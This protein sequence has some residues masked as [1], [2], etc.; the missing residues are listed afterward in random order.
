MGDVCD[1]TQL[2]GTGQSC[3]LHSL[4]LI[5]TLN[6][7]LSGLFHKPLLHNNNLVVLALHVH[8]SLPPLDLQHCNCRLP[9]NTSLFLYPSLSQRRTLPPTP[10]T[11]QQPCGAGAADVPHLW[12]RAATVLP[13]VAPAIPTAVPTAVGRGPGAARHKLRAGAGAK[14][15][16]KCGGQAAPAPRGR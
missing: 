4:G 11:E 14:C 1:V 13:T 6:S 3:P 8:T 5:S 15:G 2:C 10:L 9:L 16:A 7:T 12:R